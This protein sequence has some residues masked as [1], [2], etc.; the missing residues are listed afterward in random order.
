MKTRLLIIIGVIILAVSITYVSFAYNQEIRLATGMMISD[1]KPEPIRIAVC[2]GGCPELTDEYIHE[3]IEMVFGD[4]DKLKENGWRVYPGVG[5]WVFP[6]NST[7][8]PIYKEQKIGRSPDFEAMLDDKIFV[9]KCESNGGLWHYHYHDCIGITE[10]CEDVGG[11]HISMNKTPPACISGC[12]YV[13][14][15]S[16]VFPYEN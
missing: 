4:G 3:L 1:D 10:I 13:E 2:R 8:T 15:I 11:T 12:D 9:D 16:C 7:L 5:G 6:I 14:R